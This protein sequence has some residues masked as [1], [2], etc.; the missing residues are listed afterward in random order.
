MLEL[1]IKLFLSYALGSISGSLVMGRVFG[2]VDIRQEGSG[3]AGAT[4][5]L[6][7]HG[8]AFALPVIIIDIL[9]GALAVILVAPLAFVA[10]DPLFSRD[11]VRVCCGAAAV[12][13]HIWPMW[14][15]F[16]G[17][18]GAGT[19]VGAYLALAPMVF[20]GLLA[21]WIVG[22]VGTGYVGFSTM[23]AGVSAIGFAWWWYPGASE[24]LGFAAAMALL[25]V[26]AHRSN[27]SRM[28]LGTENRMTKAMF[29]RRSA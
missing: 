13:G 1:G 3:N 19:L 10:S 11:Y 26:F 9:K 4:N 21:V 17:G 15:D 18:K 5:A 23:L 22:V 8:A 7:T 2:G 27:I 16:R 29:W 6:R 14:H 20:P 28:V 25:V 12:I 24:L